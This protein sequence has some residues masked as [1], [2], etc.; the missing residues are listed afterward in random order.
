MKL[1]ILDIDADF[2]S[3]HEL[4]RQCTECKVRAG[5]SGSVCECCSWCSTH[6]IYV[7]WDG[8]FTCAAIFGNQCNNHGV[9]ASGE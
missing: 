8:Y 5:C 2:H 1:F 7:D 4:L 3:A 6:A 9:Q